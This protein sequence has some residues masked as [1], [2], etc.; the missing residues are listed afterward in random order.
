MALT[1]T[2]CQESL[3][4]RAEREANDYTEKNCPMPMNGNSNQVLDSFTFDKATHTFGY[5]YTLKNSLDTVTTIQPEQ[6]RQLLINGVKNTTALKAYKDENYN[7]R[8]IY[9]SNNNPDR[10]YFEAVISAK[11]YQ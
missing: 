4:E 10:I 6:Q 7:F 2:A 1:L 5:H 3:E 9:R 11:D 8:Y